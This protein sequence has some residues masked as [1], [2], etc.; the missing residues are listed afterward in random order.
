ME[1][2]QFVLEGMEL[3]VAVGWCLFAALWASL[4]R[5]EDGFGSFEDLNQ[6][7]G[8]LS[9]LE[10]DAVSA[11]APKPLMV[12]LILIQGAAAK[13]AGRASILLMLWLCAEFCVP[14][15]ETVLQL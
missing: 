14:S 12:G 13:G 10:S 9:F 11:T 8:V 3:R 1:E 7:E 4:C 15:P 6:R 5:S 2:Q